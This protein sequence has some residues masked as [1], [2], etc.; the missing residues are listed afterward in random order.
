MTITESMASFLGDWVGENRMRLMPTD[1]YDVTA[2]TAQVKITA[3]NYV[4]VSYTWHEGGVQ[5]E[6]SILLS[7]G[8]E[9][10]TVKAIWV[11]SWHSKESWMSFVG[12]IGGDSIVTLDGT[13][14]APSGPDW[15]WQI[16]I[17]PEHRSLS[18][19]NLVPGYDPYQVVE[20]TLADPA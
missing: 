20:M 18:M 13:Y 16:V 8:G 4:T 14:P 11:D 15:G 3:G 2:A 12:S 17:D 1:E 9:P 7:N 19:N 10:G 6:G 5:Q